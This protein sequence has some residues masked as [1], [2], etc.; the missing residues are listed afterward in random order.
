MAAVE[1]VEEVEVME[2]VMEVVRWVVLVVETA[3]IWEH[4]KEGRLGSGRTAALEATEV[5]WVMEIE[6][7]DMEI[8]AAMEM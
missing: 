6:A 8:G 2:E 1:E 7:M 5:T 4:L 3:A